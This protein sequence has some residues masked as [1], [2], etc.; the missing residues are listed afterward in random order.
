MELTNNNRMKLKLILIYLMT[1]V[2]VKLYPQTTEHSDSYSNY[3]EHHKNE[4]GIGNSPVYF[5]K[6]KL[7]P[8]DFIFIIPET[9]QEQNLT[10]IRYE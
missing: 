8:M 5:L 4:I 3:H 10:W 6:E 9:Y 7:L 2:P 1:I